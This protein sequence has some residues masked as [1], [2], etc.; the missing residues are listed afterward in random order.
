MNSRKKTM[1][2]NLTTSR[3]AVQTKQ[4]RLARWVVM[5]AAACAS[6][7]GLTGCTALT[8]PID[9]IPARRLPQQFFEEEKNTLVPIDI[10]LLAKDEERN[11]IL[12]PG[13]ILGITI[14]RILP[15]AEPDTIPPLPPVNFPEANSTL[16]PS[17]GFPITILEDG[18][19]SL[20]L[21]K[22]I[23]VEGLTTDQTRDKI[24]QGYLDAK[25]LKEDEQRKVSPVVTIIKKRQINIV[26]LR[27]D[28]GGGG[29]QGQQLG[30]TGR[31]VAA[32]D[33]STTGSIIKLDADRNDILNALMNTG[34]LP[35]VS[36]KNEIKILRNKQTD[37]VARMQFM[38]QYAQ[39]LATYCD[40]CSCPP[41]M[42]EDPTILKIP[43]R[44]PPGVLPSIRPED[45]VLEDGDIVLIETR[46]TEFFYTGGLLPGGQWPIPRDYDL[47]A[48]GAMALSGWGI[49]GQGRGGGGGGLAGIGGS[50]QVIPPG[51][52]YILRRTPCKGQIAIEVDLAQ[53]VNDPRQRPI[54]QPGDTLV[55]QYK[56]CEEAIN[57]G[58][59]TFF[60]F[61]IRQ[62][63]NNN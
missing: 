10:S 17:T 24:R 11:Y 29:I 57:F 6:S 1:V 37:K 62:L 63:F 32:T 21:L 15:Y 41:P 39:V 33:Y 44:L 48:L 27:Q 7:L 36:A 60:T 16:P 20:P 59:G 3:N 9:G 19:I 53:A 25:I 22:P 12:G 13:D 55:L 50:A 5:S 61:G 35:G 28:G 54:I 26:V 49:G 56:P 51:R 43:L 46:D 23:E 31:G 30:Q 47:D 45:V 52:L 18:T 38:Q 8:Q 14:D 42:P 2:T 34:G 58:I 40:P 4:R